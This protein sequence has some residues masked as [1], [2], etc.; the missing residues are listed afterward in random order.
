MPTFGAGAVVIS[1]GKVLLI[2][3]RDCEAWALPGG[4]A[5]RLSRE[6]ENPGYDL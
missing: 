2:K 1:E 5:F 4:N 6:A 3:R